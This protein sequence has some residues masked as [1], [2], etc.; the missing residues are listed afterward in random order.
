[1]LGT[2]WIYANLTSDTWRSDRELRTK[3]NDEFNDKLSVE[4]M[5]RFA[6]RLHDV[7]LIEKRR[8]KTG[9]RGMEYRLNSK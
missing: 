1:M 3:M 9:L 2:D 8:I 6:N 7:G 4:A 5:Q